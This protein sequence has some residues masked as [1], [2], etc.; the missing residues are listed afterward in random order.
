MKAID[1]MTWPVISIE[2]DATVRTAIIRMLKHHISALPVVNA[3]GRLVGILSEG[4]L[5][6]RAET[7]TQRRRPNWLEF[8]LGPGRLAGEYV[9]THGRRVK[10]VMT[11]DLVTVDESTPA[12]EIV[13]LM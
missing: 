2:P 8:L 1:I 7:G 6:R 10:E 13:S 3:E 12:D 11:Y 5:L 9:N 4:D